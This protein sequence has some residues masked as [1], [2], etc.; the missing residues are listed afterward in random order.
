MRS[1]L[2]F[3]VAL[4]LAIATG[5]RSIGPVTVPR[6]RLDY[7]TS[8]AESWKHQ[9][10]LNIVRLRYLDPPSIV[11]VGQIV[12]AYSLETGGSAA[13]QVAKAGAGDTFVGIGGHVVFTDRP[14]ITYTPVTGAKFLRRLMTPLPPESVFSTIQA[15]WP[16]DSVLFTA[17]A[18][19]NGLKNQ[20]TSLGGVIPPDPDFMRVLQL[21]RKIQLSG[22]VNLRGL[23]EGQQRE[24]MSL[25]SGEENVRR[26]TLEDIREV[27]RLLKLDPEA[28]DYQ[29]VFGATAAGDK[30]VAVLTRSILHL[31]LTMA[32]EVE[33]PAEDVAQTRAAPGWESAQQPGW[34]VWLVRIHGSKTKPADAF[35]AVNYRDHWFWI[36]DRQ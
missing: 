10:L 27:R 15:G 7:S 18:A 5:C 34:W 21:L 20:E 25:T 12:S 31:M 24:T 8:M 32:A 22:A 26:E 28:S 17:V 1:T 4:P 2:T 11:D 19:I 33:V 30:E 23:P 29:L 36:D 14:T 9:V 3:L 13:G 35:V 6:D 16:A